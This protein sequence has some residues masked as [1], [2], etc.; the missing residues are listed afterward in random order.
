MY[1]VDL[2]RGRFGREIRA[3]LGD[4]AYSD[5]RR[6]ELRLLLLIPE[7]GTTL[8]ALT[9]LAGVTKQSLSE[10][11][12]RLGRAG[13]VATGVDPQDRRVKLIRLTERGSAHVRRFD[14]STVGADILSVYE[15][16]ADG[17]AH[18]A[19]DERTRLRGFFGPARR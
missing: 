10:F 9:A 8:S 19:T 12:D 4:H 17:A 1:L 5:V 18:V 3:E 16:V 14:W 15:T 11:V 7:T 13:Y 2:I 6:S